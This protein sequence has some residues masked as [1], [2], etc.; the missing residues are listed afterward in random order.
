M[1]LQSA[2]PCSDLEIAVCYVLFSFQ[3]GVYGGVCVIF[4]VSMLCYTLVLAS[5]SQGGLACDPIPDYL[6]TICFFFSYLIDSYISVVLFA[7]LTFATCPLCPS[8]RDNFCEQPNKS[9][10]S[11][12]AVGGRILHLGQLKVAGSGS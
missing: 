8:F 10:Y 3:N 4:C 11:D 1:D 7:G 6:K 9:M 12:R 2:V 5:I